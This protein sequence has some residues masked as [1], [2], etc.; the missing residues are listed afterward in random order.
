MNIY[1]L[2]EGDGEKSVYS[3][4]LKH[5]CPHLTEVNDFQAVVSNSYFIFNGKGQPQIFKQINDS[6]QDINLI[7]KYD[8]FVIMID[9]EEMTVNNKKQ[10]VL[11]N[12]TEVLNS[13]C[14]LEI[15]VQNI[16]ME[17]WLLGNDTFYHKTS[18]NKYYQ[19]FH[20][21][22]DIT[23]NDPEF[24]PKEPNFSSSK[25]NYH[26][27]YLRN[28]L[29]SHGIRYS[30][31]KMSSQIKDAVYLQQIQDRILHTPAHL[32]SFQDFIQLTHR[33]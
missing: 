18:G 17:T 32:Q 9:A 11:S 2:V 28:M 20:D 23:I 27:Q 30:K 24:M 22:Y 13:P 10:E 3:A 6:I 4:W 19:A 7:G 12:I 8:Y 29:L 21:F 33:L 14:Q 31:S 16:C 26:F 1:M 5:I 25:A 15:I